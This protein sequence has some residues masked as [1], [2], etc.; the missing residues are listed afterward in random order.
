M[1]QTTGN[2]KAPITWA[3]G[4]FLFQNRTFSVTL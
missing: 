4:A 1:C 2:K 3:S